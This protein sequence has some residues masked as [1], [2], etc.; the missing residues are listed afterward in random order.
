MGIQDL[1]A[2][3]E[4]ISSLVIIVTL[5]VLIYEVRGTKQA[6]LQANAHERRRG[7]NTASG[8][9]AERPTLAAIWAKAEDH[10]GNS[11]FEEQAR[12]YG[13]EPHEWVQLNGYIQLRMASYVDAFSMDLP[14]QERSNNDRAMVNLLTGSASFRQSYADVSLEMT[15]GDPLGP[16][17]EYV[18][19][20]L[21]DAQ[22]SVPSRPR[23]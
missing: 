17:V 5:V 9:I 1:G 23:D 10:L 19:Q 21:A 4:F 18:D 11:R 8:T 16:F 6:T 3:G 12:A 22:I 14:E 15:P 13:L 2:I 20:L 7:R